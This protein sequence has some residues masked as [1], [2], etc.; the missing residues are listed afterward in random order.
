MLNPTPLTNDRSPRARP[1][2]QPFVIRSLACKGPSRPKLKIWDL[3]APSRYEPPQRR[4]HR[5]GPQHPSRHRLLGRLP[6][7]RRRPA[8]RRPR[9]SG[10]PRRPGPESH[11]YAEDACPDQHARADEYNDADTHLYIDYNPSRDSNGAANSDAATHCDAEPNAGACA[12]SKRD[13]LPLRSAD[14]RLRQ[15]G[16]SCG[17]RREA[18]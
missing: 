13:V 15:Q 11:L 9:D 7:R 2:C 12:H 6:A 17:T 5:P 8:L 18:G 16:R 4:P 1:I 3:P 14:L 10:A